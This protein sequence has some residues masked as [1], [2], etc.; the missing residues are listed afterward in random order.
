MKTDR[1]FLREIEPND[2]ENVFI[3]LSDP[4]I[5]KYYGVNFDSLEATEE[6]MLWFKNLKKNNKG[7][8]W[9][10]CD[11]STQKFLGAGGL[12]D[13]H[14]EHKKA[15]VGLWLLKENWGQGIMAAV[16]PL[17]LNYAF[18]K[19]LLHRIEGHVDSQNIKCKRAL[20]KLDFKYEGTMID[21]EIKNDRFVSIDIYAFLKSH[22]K[23][24]F[25]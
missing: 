4:A 6:Q 24:N 13:I 19:L 12:N 18:D 8:W 10:I 23:T 2:H 21:S 16:M 17:I 15:E 22:R 7:I 25:T 3:G 20:K 11:I 5:V 1:F 14:S 9:A